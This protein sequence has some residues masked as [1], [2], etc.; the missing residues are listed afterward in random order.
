MDKERE[1]CCVLK[2]NSATLV[3]LTYTSQSAR[4]ELRQGQRLAYMSTRY[5]A[6]PLDNS[7]SIIVVHRGEAS[8]LPV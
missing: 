1:T 6:Q 5:A 8:A 7:V 3:H 2:A 4:L